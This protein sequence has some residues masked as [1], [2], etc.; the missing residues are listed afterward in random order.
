M[1]RD[2]LCSTSSLYRRLTELSLTRIINKQGQN[3]SLTGYGK[4]IRQEFSSKFDP[5]L[6]SKLREIL[7]QFLRS[8]H[9]VSDLLD[10]MKISPNQLTKAL[11][12]LQRKN[13]LISELKPHLKIME[14]QPEKPTKQ[15][16]KMVHMS[17]GRP[18]KV[19]RLTKKGKKSLDD[20]DEFEESLK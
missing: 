6:D 3:Y 11:H 10:M 18:S 20:L 16:R 19:Y 9:S 2:S 17:R 13:Y 15:K 7:I 8:K 4:K 5:Q 14:E 12:Y 1:I